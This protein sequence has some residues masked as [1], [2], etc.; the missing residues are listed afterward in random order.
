MSSQ[1]SILLLSIFGGLFQVV[2]V[3][4]IVKNLR[5]SRIAVNPGYVGLPTRVATWTKNQVHRRPARTIAVDAALATASVGASLQ[6]RVR[7]DMD[8]LD[9][10]GKVLYAFERI[11]ELDRLVQVSNEQIGVATSAMQSRIETMGE[12]VSKQQEALETTLRDLTLG[13]VRVQGWSVI[14]LLLG[15][16][17]STAAGVLA[18]VCQ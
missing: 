13:T 12:N 9:T 1:Q 5:D 10:E 17:M 16:V 2:G 8:N 15:I 4:L 11:D 3:L 6:V 7:R 18:T 14:A